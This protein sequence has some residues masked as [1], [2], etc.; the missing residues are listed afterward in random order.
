MHAHKQ[1]L[2]EG[3]CTRGAAASDQE[4]ALGGVPPL[5]LPI[6]SLSSLPLQ[7]RPRALKQLLGLEE[8]CKI[9]SEVRG[10]APAEN[11]FGAL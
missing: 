11:E 3:C 10:R 9:P 7:V 6:P 2:T 4:F 5:T 1:E 8:H